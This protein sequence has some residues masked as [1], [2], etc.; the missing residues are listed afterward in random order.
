MSEYQSY[1]FIALDK[2]LSAT[3]MDELRAISTRAEI[4]PTQFR[5]EYNWGDL[6]AAPEMLME[7]YFDAHI[8]FANWGTHRLMLRF[9]K[10]RVD[11]KALKPYFDG[12]NAAR[13][14]VAGDHVMLD[15][16]SDTEE[17]EYEEESQRSLAALSPRRAD[18]R[19]PA[20]GLPRL[21]AR[22]DGRRFR[23]R[24]RRAACTR[25]SRNANSG[26]GGACRVSAHRR[27]PRSGGRER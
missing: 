27:R 21:A 15:F 24:R 4:S 11:L 18:A 9:P 13:C 5:N 10:A 12:G 16:I 25:R 22:S 3:Q 19:R 8:Y 1:E 6:K 14:T 26:A 2:P 7:R 23:R 20:A 17:P